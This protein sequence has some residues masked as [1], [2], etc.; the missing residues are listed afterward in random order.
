MRRSD[1]ASSRSPLL[2]HREVVTVM[3]SISIHGTILETKFLCYFDG[4]S[5]ELSKGFLFH[6]SMVSIS[7]HEG[8]TV[9]G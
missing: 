8:S 3:P 9:V 4:S 2:L 7:A 6:E 5:K 1:F